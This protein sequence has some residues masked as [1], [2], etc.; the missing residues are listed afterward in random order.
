M[1]I[2]VYKKKLDK[3]RYKLNQ[4]DRVLYERRLGSLTN[5]ITKIKVGV[6][7][8]TEYKILALKLDDAIGAVR[9][10][11]KFGVVLGGGKALYNVSNKLSDMCYLTDVIRIPSEIIC[12]NAGIDSEWRSNAEHNFGMDVTSA[13]I[14]DLNRQGILDSYLSIDEAL[15]NASSIACAYLR[16][17]TII[18]KETTPQK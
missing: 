5:G 14:V 11:F 13:K 10:A 4:V 3:N 2:D 15:K 16:T 6:P 7:T 18:R 8:V 12:R 1:R 9:K 17:N